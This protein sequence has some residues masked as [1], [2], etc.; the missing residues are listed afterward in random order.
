MQLK[1][2]IVPAEV[3]MILGLSAL[4]LSDE[5]LGLAMFERRIRRELRDFG[6]AVLA[7]V[8]GLATLG[9]DAFS[10][11]LRELAGIVT[12]SE[13][14][15]GISNL[16][17]KTISDGKAMRQRDAGAG[18]DIQEILESRLKQA[19]AIFRQSLIDSGILITSATSG[20][21]GLLVTSS[22]A[23]DPVTE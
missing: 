6:T 4:E 17:P 19:R 23:T 1:D 15:T 9:N 10:D 3:R 14:A 8:E 13:A 22:L 11:A 21:P 12:A 20:V 7:H 5:S 16:A 18:D 2:L